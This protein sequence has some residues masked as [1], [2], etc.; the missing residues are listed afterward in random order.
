M[1]VWQKDNRV[2][3]FAYCSQH[4]EIYFVQDTPAAQMA[5]L[6]SLRFLPAQERLMNIMIFI[7]L[8]IRTCAEYVRVSSIQLSS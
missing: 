6:D 4:N 8:S 7:S 2:G 1:V 5:Q 3:Y